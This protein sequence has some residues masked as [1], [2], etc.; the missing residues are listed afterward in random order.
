MHDIVAVAFITG[1]LL[2]DRAGGASRASAGA[3]A[4]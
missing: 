4:D 1:F 2:V 3:S